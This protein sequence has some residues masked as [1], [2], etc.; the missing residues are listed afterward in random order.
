MSDSNAV[1]PVSSIRGRVLVAGASGALGGRVARRLLQAGVPVRAVGRRADALEPLANAGAELVVGDLRDADTARRACANVA[2]VVT[3][4][5]NVM[6]T[7]DRS[8]VTTDRPAYRTLSHAMV[9]AGVQRWVHVSA[10]GIGPDNPVDYFRVKHAVDEMITTAGVPWVLVQPSAFM[11]TWMTTLFGESMR[12]ERKVTLFG[13]G[14]RVSNFVALDDVA[15]VICA[16]LAD[17][18]VHE[19]RVPVGG[20]STLTWLDTVAEIEQAYGLRVRRSFVPTWL[21]SIGRR[22]AGR[23]DEKVGRLMSLGY[24]SATTDVRCD[25]WEE[26]ARRFGVQPMSVGAY[27]AAERAALASRDAR[28]TASSDAAVAS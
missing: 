1:E 18:T 7:G 11:E 17:A 26:T 25:A 12:R 28:T 4:M 27:L 2:Q 15:A 13:R 16:I 20:P 21:L 14:D 23:F 3:T 8:P 9:E 10:L 24:W 22:V 6:G 5:N 19:E